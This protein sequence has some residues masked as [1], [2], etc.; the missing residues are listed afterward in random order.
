MTHFHFIPQ[1]V[2]QTFVTCTIQFEPRQMPYTMKSTIPCKHKNK[3]LAGR[4][5]FELTKTRYVLILQD[6]WRHYPTPNIDVSVDLGSNT[7]VCKHAIRPLRFALSVVRRGYISCIPRGN[8]KPMADHHS[9][10]ISVC[11]PIWPS[12]TWRDHV[13]VSDIYILLDTT[14]ISRHRKSDTAEFNR[15]SPTNV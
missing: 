3:K 9:A 1:L 7:C 11:L 10:D 13:P 5:A 4:S 14:R 15:T 6:A 12:I 8:S 2:D